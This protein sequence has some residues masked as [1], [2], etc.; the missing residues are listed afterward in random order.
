[1]IVL[2]RRLVMPMFDTRNEIK[3]LCKFLMHV[4]T[5]KGAVTLPRLKSVQYERNLLVNAVD[6][7][8]LQ[9]DSKILKSCT[10]T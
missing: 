1:M 5:C 9:V 4:L 8:W 6:P 10:T 7:R 3:D 2:L